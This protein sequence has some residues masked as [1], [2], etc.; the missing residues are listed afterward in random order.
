MGTDFNKAAQV[1]RDLRSLTPS[2]VS[3]EVSVALLTG[4]ADRPYVFGLATALNAKGT[5]MDLIG[6]DDLDFPEFH[7]RPG[8]NFLNL[9][10]D[11]RTDAN[12]PTKI[13]RVLK[14]YARLIRYA[15]TARPRVFHILW[16]NKFEHF[17][18]TILMLYY[19]VL[20]KR[21]AFT[22]HNV[23]SGKRDRT[24]TILNRLTLK[25]QYRLA[26]RL[27]VHTE[28][29][30]TELVEE[31]GVRGACVT[32]IPFGINNAVPDTD[33]TRAA[34]RELLGIRETD[35]TMLFFGNITPY[36]GLEYLIDAFQTVQVADKSYRLIIAGRPDNCGSYWAPIRQRVSD[37][38]QGDRVLLR[39][40]FVP[41]EETEVYFKAADVLVLPYTHVYQ[42]G[43]LFLGYRFGL[44]V[45][46]ADVG[47]LKEDIVENETGFVFSSHNSTDLANA[48]RK[49][50]ASEVYA[51]LDFRRKK[52][53]DYAMAR[54]SWE[55][56]AQITL[57]AY[58]QLLPLD[59]RRNSLNHEVVTTSVE[60]TLPTK[61]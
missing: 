27:F 22:V 37:N 39:D 46:A 53:K 23:N 10:G 51:N 57:D 13:I 61:S 41:D 3:H 20:G 30:K 58:K 33:L 9:R 25:F 54:H 1:G 47:S 14:Y 60:E 26:D 48:I 6:S 55:L 32:V 52:I 8:V 15:G 59:P 24:D 19:K 44:P 56:V 31:F 42:S 21:I 2:G 45:L 18:R 12:L 50:F 4:G 36:K 38:T 40:E 29:M 11:Q 16:N 35:K 34:A 28:K 7:T 49:Y 17:D 5:A 43:V